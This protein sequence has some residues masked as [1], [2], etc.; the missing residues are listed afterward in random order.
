MDVL[1]RNAEKK[2]VPRE[3]ESGCGHHG[4]WGTDSSNED[5][6]RLSAGLIQRYFQKNS[7]GPIQVF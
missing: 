3:S 1:S 5:R 6:W 7:K 4:Q 2:N